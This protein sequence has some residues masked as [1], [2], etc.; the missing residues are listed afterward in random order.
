MNH[1]CVGYCKTL[2]S[3]KELSERFERYSEEW[4]V[5][6]PEKHWFRADCETGFF[7]FGTSVGDQLQHTQSLYNFERRV[8]T[9]V[10]G[11]PTFERFPQFVP[12][13]S[14]PIADWIRQLRQ[15]YDHRHIFESLGLA[16][17]GWCLSEVDLGERSIT[18]YGAPSGLSGMFYTDNP[19]Y[20]AVSNKP[21][22]LG[23][24][25]DGG[26]YNAVDK[27]FL[28]W[29]VALA[30]VV[31]YRSMWKQVHRIAP[32]DYIRFSA[33]DG[34]NKAE[35]CRFSNSPFVAQPELST[36]ENELISRGAEELSAG[37]QW[38][39]DC[40][41]EL[42]ADLT[43][44][45]DSRLMLSIL[46]G[47][48][49]HSKINRF[50]TYGR[51]DNGD[52]IVAKLL[53]EKASL[54]NWHTIEPRG[55]LDKDTLETHLPRFTQTVRHYDFFC[56]AWDSMLPCELSK[57]P[58]FS[59]MIGHS[60]D[61]YRQLAH[62]LEP[63]GQ[64]TVDDLINWGTTFDNLGILLPGPARELKQEI[65][66]SIYLRFLNEGTINMGLRNQIGAWDNA[67]ATNNPQRFTPL[68]NLTLM[69][70]ANSRPDIHETI[71]YKLMKLFHPAVLEVPFL[72]QSWCGPDA[73]L[74]RNDG[75]FHEPIR[76]SHKHQAPWQ[77]KLFLQDGR[78]MLGEII[79]SFSVWE[80][81]LSQKML[82]KYHDRLRPSDFKKIDIL[83]IFNLYSSTV[84]LTGKAGGRT[85]PAFKRYSDNT[86][87]PPQQ[88][89]L[90][91]WSRSCA[92]SISAAASTIV[93]RKSC[94]QSVSNLG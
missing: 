26:P 47:N 75:Y 84:F 83:R 50:E 91:T 55:E 3:L 16:G 85:W 12:G 18:A 88:S 40:G 90:S 23:A 70:L 25:Q 64:Y 63:S 89:K 72:N 51:P 1:Y 31:G 92:Q 93:R 60:S 45:K 38:L 52:L 27:S 76:T 24:L 9:I 57:L 41:L 94:S 33:Q 73:Q 7:V 69:R 56:S 68:A 32:C 4:S 78:K 8:W 82:Q 6:V 21:S 44:G 77:Y 42:T 49:L 14:M 67:R 35:V 5:F 43:G 65:R 22:I 71:H 37:V 2:A 13:R 28:L 80:E 87:A 19:S 36:H 74:A 61:L 53:A 46:L 11:F 39:V 34:A 29:Q 54:N 58:K 59:R 10:G 17:G 79:D 48:G 66:N 15:K 81:F 86:Q 20:F 30:S 62:S